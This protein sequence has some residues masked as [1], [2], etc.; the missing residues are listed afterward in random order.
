MVLKRYDIFDY[1]GYVEKVG[2]N[3]TREEFKKISGLDED[4]YNTAVV[5]DFFCQNQKDIEELY[6]LAP[7]IKH[8]REDS[9]KLNAFFF[10]AGA[11]YDNKE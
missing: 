10:D 2:Y 8:L 1:G 3:I 4:I 6:N 9:D 11:K 5:A 7:I